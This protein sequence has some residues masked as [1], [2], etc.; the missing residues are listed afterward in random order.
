MSAMSKLS[1]S[2]V[3]KGALKAQKP[4]PTLIKIT[5]QKLQT[6]LGCDDPYNLYKKSSFEEFF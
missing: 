3:Q 6:D 5:V 4:Q 1:W 2:H